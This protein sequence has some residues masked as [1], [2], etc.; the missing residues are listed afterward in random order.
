MYKYPYGDSQQLNLD[1]I[2]AKLKELEASGGSGGADLE[3]VSNALLSLTYNTSTAYRRYDY[4]FLNGKLYRCLTDTSGVFNPTAWQEALIGDDL[5]VLTRWINAIDAA[6][7]VD[8]KFDTT[9]TNGKLQQKYHD[10]YHDVVEVD[11]TPVQNSKRPL[12]SNAGY[13]LNGA[14]NDLAEIKPNIGMFER[15]AIIGDSFA[16]GSIST[17]GSTLI[18]YPGESW[19]RM[20]ASKYGIGLMLYA[21]GGVS[22]HDFM[23]STHA[24]YN[25][26]GFGALNFDTSQ[27]GDSGLY[28]LCIGIN[29]ATADPDSTNIGT[30]A[31]IKTDPDQNS[32]TFWGNYGKIIQ[33]IQAI[34][35][36]GRIICCGFKRASIPASDAA[37]ANYNLAIKNIAQ[38]FSLP[39]INPLDNPFFTSDLY[40]N[41]MVLRHP[42]APIFSAYAKAMDELIQDCIVDNLAYFK[43][44]TGANI[45]PA[46]KHLGNNL[47]TYSYSNVTTENNT[48]TNLGTVNIP[49]KGTYIILATA[50]FAANGA[51]WR[52]LG[53]ASSASSIW[54]SRYLGVQVNG[55]ANNSTKILQ[56]FLIQVTID[57]YTLY[58]NVSQNSGGQLAVSSP[59]LNVIKIA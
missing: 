27:Y 8:V 37:Y 53:I 2:L 33:K 36:N 19:G 24:Y 51:G 31:D 40:L 10:E 21:K 9:G 20:L 46:S 45:F 13:E 58:L 12:S 55:D 42:T 14:I 15:F 29:D 28:L 38:H 4:A 5:A 54:L 7:V 47:T 34:N 3:E 23:D 17:D 41:N 39:Y 1:W 57:N 49:Y 35:A 48:V 11:Y 22:T 30:S 59:G 50:E 32:N 25:K 43:V 56:M 44:Y 52:R 26:T 18:D 6:A 16:A